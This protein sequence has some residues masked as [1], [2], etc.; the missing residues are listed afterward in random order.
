MPVVAALSLSLPAFSADRP[1][2][3]VDAALRQALHACDRAR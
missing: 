1:A 3:E 2:A